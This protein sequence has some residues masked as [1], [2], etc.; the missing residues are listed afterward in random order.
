MEYSHTQSSDAGG[1]MRMAGIQQCN[2]LSGTFQAIDKIDTIVL[3]L[4]YNQVCV[5]D[6]PRGVRLEH[7]PSA[8]TR[9][10]NLAPLSRAAPQHRRSTHS[11]GH[12]RASPRRYVHGA[13]AD[14]LQ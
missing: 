7:T 14:P 13:V 12:S 2:A 9:W 8:R 10:C 4:P 1:Y 11:T 5:C 3:P 6:S